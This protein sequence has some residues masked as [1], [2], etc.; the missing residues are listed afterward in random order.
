[1]K[2]ILRPIERSSLKDVFVTRFEEL[3]LSGK[4]SMGQR[5]PSERELALQLGVSRP[6]VHEGLLDLASK[7]LV[8]MKPRVGTVVNDYRK[9]GSLALLNSL[10]NYYKGDLDPGLLDSL[11]DM[12]HLVEMETVRLA[13]QNRSDQD[14]LSFKGIVE[15][16]LG[17]D[18]TDL[19]SIREIDFE[20]HH[21]IALASGNMVYPFLIRSFK[22]VYT[23]LSGKFFTDTTVV[24]QVFNFHKELVSA[25]EDKDTPRA[26]GIME[27]LLE[28][29]RSY[30]K[31]IIES[32][33]Q[34]EQGQD[35]AKEKYK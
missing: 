32:S 23:N 34:D 10:V 20:F 6:V 15:K 14:M 7:G 25:F 19:D 13:S 35:L 31:K 16:E 3:I 9:E 33:G 17:L 30:L 8:T 18:R 28:H 24:P 4:I 26:L 5:L 1:M 12:R 11:L 22:P 2:D 29:G 27:E 21:L